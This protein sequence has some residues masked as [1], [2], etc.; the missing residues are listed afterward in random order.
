MLRS[1]VSFRMNYIGP[2]LLAGRALDS[3]TELIS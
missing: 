2:L 3:L 1:F